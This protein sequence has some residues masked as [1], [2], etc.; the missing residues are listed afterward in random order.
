MHIFGWEKRLEWDEK[1][2]ELSKLLLIFLCSPQAIESFTYQS[3]RC[4]LWTS[5]KLSYCADK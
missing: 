3:M 2:T 5:E 1:K 4:N